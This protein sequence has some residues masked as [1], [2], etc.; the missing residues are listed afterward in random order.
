MIT[1][2]TKHGTVTAPNDE[3]VI[4]AAAGINGRKPAPNKGRPKGPGKRWLPACPLCRKVFERLTAVESHRCPENNRQRVPLLEKE[5][6]RMREE[7]KG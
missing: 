4:S 5:A 7:G 3:A 6:A 1:Y 2:K